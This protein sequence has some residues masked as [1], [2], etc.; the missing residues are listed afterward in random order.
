MDSERLYIDGVFLSGHDGLPRK[1]I[2]LKY[3]GCF[4]SAQNSVKNLVERWQAG[5]EAAAT[6]L[7]ERFQPDL[8]AIVRAGLSDELRQRIEPADILQSAFKSY[9][10]RAR[11]GDYPLD[12]ATSLRQLLRTITLNKIR[13]QAERHNAQRRDVA[14]EVPLDQSA[15]PAKAVA[16]EPTPDEMA[17]AAEETAALFAGLKPIEAEMVR[18]C[19]DGHST[20]ESAARLGYSRQGVRRLLN[21]VGQRLALRKQREDENE[22]I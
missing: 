6:E 4:M 13:R 14:R 15:L 18:L 8:V 3:R 11:N 9:F 12:D 21:R 17:I 10:V 16:R 2:R 1:G 5:E 20:A 19:L 22:K 7:F